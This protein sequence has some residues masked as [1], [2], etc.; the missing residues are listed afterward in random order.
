MDGERAVPARPSVVLA[1]DY[2]TEAGGAE[3]VVVA[4]ASRFP[5]A[6]ILTSAVQVASLDPVL[7]GRQLRT[8][9]LGPLLADKGR[10]KALF[11]LLPLGFRVMQV[12]VADVLLTSSSGFAHHLRPPAGMLHAWYCHTP[13]RFLW[14]PD[15]SFA[16]RPRT[17]HALAPALAL[18]RRLDRSAAARVDL[19]IANSRTTADRIRAVYGRDAEVLW[20]P[21]PVRAFQPTDE[22]SGRLL[23]LSRLLAYK[24][25]DVAIA[26]A[27]AAG[28]PLDIVGDG[29]ERP[30]LERLAGPGVRFLGRLS[31]AEARVHLARCTA[32]LVP[33]RE[34]LGITAV[35]AQASGRPPIVLAAG[36]GLETVTDGVSGYHVPSD[37][38]AAWVDAIG[39]AAAHPVATEA[40]LAAA[41][42]MDTPV[43]LV[44]LDAVLA[45]ALATQAAEAPGRARAVA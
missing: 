9:R 29:P 41:R 32:L 44:R 5:D 30:R 23:V 4:L 36:G 24:R 11:P 34:D 20:P 3:R 22:R 27:G 38:P 37:H 15:A 21:I 33:G 43:F 10:A 16:D 17:G 26:A 13:P 12:P 8:F 40:L 45:R 28:M 42:R 25:I 18:L 6:P 19:L 1:H 14:D 31:D 39:R 7:R 2:L 35:E